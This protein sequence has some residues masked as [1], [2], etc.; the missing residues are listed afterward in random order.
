MFRKCLLRRI[1]KKNMPVH[2][3]FHGITKCVYEKRNERLRP[4]FMNLLPE[5]EQL[6]LHIDTNSMYS[7]ESFA[8]SI[9][10]LH[11]LSRNDLHLS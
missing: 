10:L 11:D 4:Y 2:E 9:G 3:L 1:G 7:F 6:I 5:N 8:F